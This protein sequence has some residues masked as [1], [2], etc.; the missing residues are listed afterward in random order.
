[1]LCGTTMCELPLSDEPPRTRA[2]D[3]IL[4]LHDGCNPSRSIASVSTTFETVLCESFMMI[5]FEGLTRLPRQADE[6]R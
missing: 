5:H 3:K 1:M 2:K 6:E 4:L